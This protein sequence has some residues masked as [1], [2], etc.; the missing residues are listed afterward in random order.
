MAVDAPLFLSIIRD[1]YNPTTNQFK[2]HYD[3]TKA[4]AADIK[5]HTV[6]YSVNSVQYDSLVPILHGSFTFSIT[7]PDNASIIED[8]SSYETIKFDLLWETS[9]T[10]ALPTI[11]INPA[12]CGFA[13]TW[14]FNRF[15]DDKDMLSS[16]PS[17]FA[18]SNPNLVLSHKLFDYAERQTLFGS[19]TY[20]FKITINDA[21]ST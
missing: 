18:I 5:T 9:K 2:I 8:V 7:C 14:S 16:L 15:S 21:S 12:G 20:Y 1:P 13:A 3:S 10:I 11:Q 19:H 17:V 4:F 6:V